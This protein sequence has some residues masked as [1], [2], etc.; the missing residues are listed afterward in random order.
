VPIA[1]KPILFYGIE[2]IRDA[3]IRDIAIIVGDTADEVMQAVG[4]GDRFDARHSGWHT[5]SRS[6]RTTWAT[7]RS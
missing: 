7:I 3:G 6:P 5:R 2:A 1:N 4:N